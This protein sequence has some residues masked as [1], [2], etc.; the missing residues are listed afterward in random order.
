MAHNK[1]TVEVL[2]HE[3]EV[4]NEE[5]EMV[6]TKT[7]VGSIG[8]LANH[9]PVL[10][11]LDPTELR[12]YRSVDSQDIVRFAQSEGYMQVGGNR[13]LLLV[14]EA[15]EPGSLDAGQLRE[16]LQQAQSEL[17]SAGDD[18]ERRRVAQRNKL[19]WEAFLAIAE[20]HTAS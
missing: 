14:E 4:F 18:S 1:F 5:V 20:G 19:R 6:S 12:L 3:G 13:A 2:T 9:A 7:S 17:D 15:H 10:A 11:M 16:R 8:V